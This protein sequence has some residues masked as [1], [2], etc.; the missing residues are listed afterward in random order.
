[1]T[2]PAPPH[3][4]VWDPLR[5]HGGVRPKVRDPPTPRAGGGTPLSDSSPAWFSEPREGTY[6]KRYYSL[7]LFISCTRL[8]SLIAALFLLTGTAAALPHQ[9]VFVPE[10]E[11]VWMKAMNRDWQNVELGL[12]FG[13]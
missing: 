8:F 13:N 10:T 9:V 11:T 1:M 4:K 12:R 5:G 6:I 2:G 3:Q 7:R